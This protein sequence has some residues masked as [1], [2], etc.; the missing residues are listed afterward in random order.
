MLI[1]SNKSLAEFNLTR[2]EEFQDKKCKLAEMYQE[3]REINAT[4]EEKTTK[5]S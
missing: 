4:V 5:L 2:A 3:L 1:A